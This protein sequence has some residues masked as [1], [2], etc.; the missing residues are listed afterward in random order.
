MDY[1]DLQKAYYQDKSPGKQTY[2]ALYTQRYAGD[3][4]IPLVFDIDGAPAFV[5]TTPFMLNAVAL[6]LNGSKLAMR[7]ISTLPPIAVQSLK[8]KMA[9]DE[10][11]QTL[12]IEH[13]HST[14][15]EIGEAFRSAENPTHRARLSGMAAK[16]LML[17]NK[18]HVP[19]QTSQDIRALYDELCLPEV[20]EEDATNRPDGLLFR[21]NPVHISKRS[22][23]VIHNGLFPESRILSAMDKALR[24]ASDAS[25]NQLIRIA[26]FHFLFGYIHPFYDGNGRMARFISSYQLNGYLDELIG[27]R[28]SYTLHENLRLYQKAFIQA[29]NKHNRGDLTLFVSTFLHLLATSYHDLHQLLTDLLHQ[30]NHYT[31]RI[32][33]LSPNLQWRRVAAILLQNTLYGNGDLTLDA[34]AKL[35]K[36]SVAS[37]RRLMA[38]APFAPL[39]SLRKEGRRKTYSLNLS[40]L[41]EA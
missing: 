13:V 36:T 24:I 7:M 16:Y 6:V 17:I 26:A 20:L 39:F 9:T 15:Q 25:I 23:K 11:M 8:M 31:E 14:R 41:D 29:E 5:V 37:I 33:A 3:A 1:M 35:S 19:L 18:A 32:E 2:N 34:L 4:T 12:D 40:L 30:M 38:E 21:A 22:D 28:L 27:L 10:V